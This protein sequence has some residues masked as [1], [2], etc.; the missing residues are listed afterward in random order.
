MFHKEKIAD[1]V[2]KYKCKEG[3]YKDLDEQMNLIW[4]INVQDDFPY[5]WQRA[6][7]ILTGLGVYLFSTSIEKAIFSSA[8]TYISFYALQDWLFDN[9]LQVV[10]MPQYY[11]V[12]ETSG[13]QSLIYFDGK[14]T[15]ILDTIESII[16]KDEEG[17]IMELIPKDKDK[18]M[19]QFYQENNPISITREVFDSCIELHD[20]VY[21][22]F[23]DSMSTSETSKL[24][25]LIRFPILIFINSLLDDT[26]SYAWLFVVNVMMTMIPD[27]TIDVI[28]EAIKNI[29]YDETTFYN[30]SA[31]M[32]RDSHNDYYL[33]THFDDLDNMKFYNTYDAF[34]S[35]FTYNDFLVDFFNV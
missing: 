18:I 6:M 30:L 33:G 1:D 29:V 23:A 15:K 24:L 10:T 34:T 2:L 11:V 19:H 31:F 14:N 26:V 28:T 5:F 21:N 22:V 12:K 4:R 17:N 3:L 35:L 25:F 27:F 20:N 32:M 8:F 9:K 16:V 7:T 13:E